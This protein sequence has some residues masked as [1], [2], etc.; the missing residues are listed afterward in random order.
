M[1]KSRNS[2]QRPST[3]LNDTTHTSPYL[4][5]QLASRHRLLFGCFGRESIVSTV[6]PIVCVC[7]DAAVHSFSRFVLLLRLYLRESPGVGKMGGSP[8]NDL[9]KQ[10]KKGRSPQN[11]TSRRTAHVVVV[12]REW[13]WWAG[14]EFLEASDVRCCDNFNAL[15][16]PH[17][18]RGQQEP[19]H[20]RRS[21]QWKRKTR[22]TSN[23]NLITSTDIRCS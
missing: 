21:V 12:V 10:H 7:S 11:T 16:S 23:T 8:Q 17:Q 1:Q 22:A 20:G 3:I 13:K 5:N 6:S 2:K 15:V 14:V 9:M 19:Q 4:A 18:E